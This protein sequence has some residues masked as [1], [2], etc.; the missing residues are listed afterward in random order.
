MPKSLL[1]FI[2]GRPGR[3]VPHLH[4]VC[5]C[6][7]SRFSMPKRLVDCRSFPGPHPWVSSLL[8]PLTTVLVSRFRP[9]YGTICLLGYVNRSSSDRLQHLLLSSL[10]LSTEDG[11]GPFPLLFSLPSVGVS[12]VSTAPGLKIALSESFRHWI[13]RRNPKPDS[14][15]CLTS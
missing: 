1:L 2:P 14:R 6:L 8:T 11:H 9:R 15:A 4:Q 12:F 3:R 13:S 5:A 10:W 7:H